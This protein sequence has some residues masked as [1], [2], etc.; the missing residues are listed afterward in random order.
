[1]HQGLISFE[2]LGLVL[3]SHSGFGWLQISPSLNVGR[4]HMEGE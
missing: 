2:M 4:V 3:C 1:M